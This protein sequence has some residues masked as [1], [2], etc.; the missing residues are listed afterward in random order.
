[1]WIESWD[2]LSRINVWGELFRTESCEE[3][4]R[5]EVIGKPLRIEAWEGLLLRT[6]FWGES[7]MRMNWSSNGI[8][9]IELVLEFCKIV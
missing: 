8:E 9:L 3:S 2:E 1:L 6:E 4:L 7:F 5:K